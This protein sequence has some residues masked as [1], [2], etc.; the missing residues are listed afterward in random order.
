MPSVRTSGDRTIPPY[1]HK[2]LR[3]PHVDLLENYLV[4]AGYRLAIQLQVY[5]SVKLYGNLVNVA[6][7][8]LLHG[9]QMQ[10][11]V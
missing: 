8:T 10:S 4:D 7:P 9:L 6:H 11:G 1:P 2:T 5:V 3:H